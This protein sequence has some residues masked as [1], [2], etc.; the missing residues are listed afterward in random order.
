M[1]KFVFAPFGIPLLNEY[2]VA[3]LCAMGVAGVIVHGPL[4]R[5]GFTRRQA[6]LLPVA[7]TYIGF[8]GAHVLYGIT[9]LGR[10]DWDVWFRKVFLSW[11]GFVWYGGLAASA[12][13]SLV[14]ARRLK[15]PLLAMTDALAPGA[16]MALAFGRLGCFMHG[17]CYGNPTDLPWGVIFPRSSFGPE[18]HLHP[19]QLYEFFFLNGVFLIHRWMCR[20]GGP[21]QPFTGSTTAFWFMVSAVGRY[22]FEMFRGDAIRGVW[23][24]GI[25]TSQFLSVVLFVVGL[26]IWRSCRPSGA[27]GSGF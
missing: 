21:F 3:A 10:Y 4:R 15:I 14:L 16:F 18:V 2:W 7:L 26:W 8:L 27:A 25:S 6:L 17:C 12:I 5:L 22:L 19:T 20:A 9:I 11:S 13:A 1:Y 24:F 23:V